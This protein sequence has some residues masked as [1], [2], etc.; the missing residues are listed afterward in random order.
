MQQLQLVT[1]LLVSVR[2]LKEDNNYCLAYYVLQGQDWSILRIFMQNYI[3]FKN[4]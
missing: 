1:G 3:L 2:V 4:L